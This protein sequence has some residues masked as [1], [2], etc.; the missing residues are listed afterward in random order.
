MKTLYT[1]AD[2]LGYKMTSILHLIEK[3][4]VNEAIK[5]AKEV[6]LS[7]TKAT[8]L[9]RMLHETYLYNLSQEKDL[10]TRKMIELSHLFDKIDETTKNQKS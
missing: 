2:E 5:K 4:S 7:L 8:A 3:G 6:T 9:V 10:C 1:F